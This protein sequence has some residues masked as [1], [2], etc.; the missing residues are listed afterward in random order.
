MSEQQSPSGRFNLLEKA[1]KSNLIVTPRYKR[2]ESKSATT[3]STRRVVTPTTSGRFSLRHKA[4]LG[5]LKQHWDIIPPK[6]KTGGSDDIDL[7]Y[8]DVE[9][10]LDRPLVEGGAK[11]KNDDN[12]GKSPKK[13][14]DYKNNADTRTYTNDTS[15]VP[16]SAKIGTRTIDLKNYTL[17][18]K[19]DWSR[20]GKNSRIAYEKKDGKVVEG[21]CLTPLYANEQSDDEMMYL[22]AYNFKPG[23]KKPFKWSVKYND[24]NHLWLH[25]GQ[26]TIRDKEYDLRAKFNEKIESRRPRSSSSSSSDNIQLGAI[27]NKVDNNSSNLDDLLQRHDELKKRNEKLEDDIENIMNFLTRKFQNQFQSM[28]YYAQGNNMQSQVL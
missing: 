27:K 13:K 26:G 20:I 25:P 1:K 10:L 19:D 12:I 11:P 5:G 17:L 9:E 4:S 23:K 18:T 28:G 16:T 15:V 6:R 3:V 2:G 24:I 7:E 22:E 8:G 14:Y 21:T